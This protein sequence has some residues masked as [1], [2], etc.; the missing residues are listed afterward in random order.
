[1][2]KKVIVI[3]GGIAGL[4]AGVYAQKCGFDVTVLES[5]NIAGGNCTS[6]KRG[7][8]LFEGGMH[9]LTGSDKKEPIN[10]LWRYVGALNDSVNIHYPEPFFEL[11]LEKTSIR[12]YRNIDTT[13]QYLLELSP[14]DAKEIKKLCGYIRKVKNLAMPVTDLRGVKVTKKAH[15][16][17]SLLFSAVSAFRVMAALSK[18]S[19]SDYINSFTHE[20]IRDM[21]RSFTSEKNGV[22]PF[23][24]T[25]GTLAR[26]DGGF[27][28]G[29]SLPFADRIVKTFT[30]LGGEILYNTRADRVLIENGNAVGVMAGGKKISADAV[31]I[32]ADT[33]AIDHLFDTPPKAQWLDEMQATTEPTMGTLVSLGINADL[34]KYEK[35]YVFKPKT[36]IKLGNEAYDFISLNN[37][38]ADPVYS[39]QGKTAMTI[40]LGGD[41]YDF[42]KKAKEENRYDEEKKK[43]A[44]AVIQVISAQMPEANGKVEVTDV[45]TPLTYERYCGNWKGSWMTE[46]KPGMKMKTYPAIINGLHGIYFAGH[47]MM[48]PGG[49]PVALMSAR[50]AVQHLCRD[51]GTLFVSEE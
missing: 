18:I 48:P 12:I 36:P 29:G 42:W 31:I 47:R 17:L 28:E 6:W 5:H 8:Y 2:K 33:M 37:Y 41:T 43:I 4:S 49:L 3:G 46:M 25:M 1:M 22:L 35:N 39:P 23:V 9:W 34:K 32:T 30:A 27:P 45:A 51:T 21:I 44:E 11:A 38:A 50:I 24:F 7:G 16:P 20:G 26:G 13:E 10:K 15:M 14:A 19:H 40:H